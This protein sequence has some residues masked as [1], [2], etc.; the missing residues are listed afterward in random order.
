M[1]HKMSTS[2]SLFY[3][4]QSGQPYSYVYAGSM[5]NDNGRQTNADLI[6][7]PT[8]TQLNNMVF[9]STT[10]NNITYPPQQQKDLL[11]LFIDKD[12][13][14]KKRRGQ[15]AERNGAKLPFTHTIDI[16]I[17]QNFI[18]KLNKKLTTVS[19]SYDIFN[20][21]NMLNKNWGKVYFLSGDNFQ[22]IRFAG[23]SNTTTLVPQYQFTPLSG[24]PYSLQ[25]STAPGNSARWI[26]QLGLKINF[27]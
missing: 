16:R 8:Q 27:N 14:L 6:Y 10:V 1:K 18:L 11:N 17:Q 12:K 25:G 5:I 19:I 3:N 20:F 13:Y 7:I 15:F 23:F 22:L 26:S 9:I 4:G 24:K 2:F 21:T